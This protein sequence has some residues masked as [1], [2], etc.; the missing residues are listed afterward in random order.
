MQTRFCICLAALLAGTLVIAQVGGGGTIQGTVT[1][2]PTL[3]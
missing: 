2:P 1:D 3:W